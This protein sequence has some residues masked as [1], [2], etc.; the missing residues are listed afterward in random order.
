MQGFRYVPDVA[1]LQLNIEA[2]VGC[3]ACVTVCPH[4]VFQVQD[5][6][7]RIVDKDACM[8]CG[9]CA[10]NCPTAAVSVEPGV[11]CASYLIQAWLHE[12]GIK[13]KPSVCCG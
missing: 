2:C 3:G 12:L 8:E 1:T 7:A 4:R 6:K 11:G 10:M 9:A 13:K 5:R